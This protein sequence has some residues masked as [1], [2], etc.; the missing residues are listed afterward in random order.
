MPGVSAKGEDKFTFKYHNSLYYVNDF[1]IEKYIT[2]KDGSYDVT[3]VRDYE[4]LVFETGLSFYPIKNLEFGT[5]F[6][7]ISYYGGF[8][9]NIIETF[10]SV[11]KFPNGGREYSSQNNIYV[12]IKNNNN[13]SLSLTTSIF[14]LG[15]ID[16]WTKWTFLEKRW[17]SLALSGAFKIPTGKIYA[18]SGSGY[19]DISFGVL[20]DFRPIWILSF[21]LQSGL[22]IPFDSFLP[23]APSKPYPMFNG[24]AG[25]ELNPVSF[26]SLIVQ[27][28]FKTSA[29]S[30]DIKHWLYTDTDYLALPQTNI[31]GGLV[32]AYK[33]FRWQFYFE[34][35]A[36]TNG[37]TDLTLNLTF[38]HKLSLNFG[39]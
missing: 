3:L 32:F 27:L 37:G 30:S 16:L 4:S 38:S 13:I 24:I 15:D 1:Q 11:F 12:N 35:D 33:G 25:I 9:D 7:L 17:I 10:H 6:R 2:K 8:V 29:M 19:P 18:L 22:V 14:S 28:N 20:A 36:I 34:E 26:F 23:D 21:Y 5:D 31:L 39:L